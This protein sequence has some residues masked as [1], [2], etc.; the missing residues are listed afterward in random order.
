MATR[1]ERAAAK[2]VRLER[3]A[4][5][6]VGWIA[7][8]DLVR[9]LL[10]DFEGNR[11]GPVPARACVAIAD[12]GAAAAARQPAVLLFEDGDPGRPLLMGLVALAPGAALLEQLL[13]EPGA[14]PVKDRRAARAP[15]PA[16]AMVPAEA[17]VDGRRVVLE[18]RDEVVLR[19]GEA[20]ITLSRDGKVTVRGARI[21]STAR[22]THRIRGGSVQIN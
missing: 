3:I 15:E 14:P 12:P 4:G 18:G 21:V 17:K 8:H 6:R 10:V 19:C 13:S 7:G 5:A 2:P 20:S 16:P 11:A 9:G 22:G 1:R